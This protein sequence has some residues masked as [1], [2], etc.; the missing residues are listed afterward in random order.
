[1]KSYPMPMLVTI[2]GYIYFI[3][4]DRIGPIKIG[5]TTNIAKRILNLQVASPYP[6][7]LLCLFPGNVDM[8]QKIHICYKEMRMEGEWFLP[9]PFILK[10]IDGFLDMNKDCGFVLPIPEYDIGDDFENHDKYFS[11]IQNANFDWNGFYASNDFQAFKKEQD[12]DK[13][14]TILDKFVIG[15]YGES[16]EEPVARIV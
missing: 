5:F 6:L 2:T 8:E 10:E 12:A 1:V 11:H 13:R 16:H 15:F 7:N 14:D 9:H 3:Q 4:M